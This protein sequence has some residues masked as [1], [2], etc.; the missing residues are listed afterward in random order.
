V[1]GVALLLSLDSEL[2]RRASAASL[3]LPPLEV[4]LPVSRP[5]MV[6]AHRSEATALAQYL[7]LPPCVFTGREKEVRDL[8]RRVHRGAGRFRPRFPDAGLADG[9]GDATPGDIR[10]TCTLS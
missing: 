2:D 4:M 8:K 6:G 3:P 1:P 5:L 9:I 7:G 10:R